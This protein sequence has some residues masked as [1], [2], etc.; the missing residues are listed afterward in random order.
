MKNSRL[1]VQFALECLL[2]FVLGSQLVVAADKPN[3][4]VIWGDDIGI[5]NISAYNRG[6]MGYA[7]PNIDRL[8]REGMMF[9]DYY[10]EQSCTA[11][12]SAFI[13]GQQPLR[14]GLTKVGSPGSSVGIQERDPTVAELIKP[15][16]YATG[17][18]GKNH[19][20]DRD[21]YLPTNHGFDEFTI[22]IAEVIVGSLRGFSGE[23]AT[24]RLRSCSRLCA[25][26][27][28]R[29]DW[30]PVLAYGDSIV[31]AWPA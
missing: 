11:D 24:S 13:T 8:A 7:T 21:E 19:L 28:V 2:G 30:G 14:T 18:F 20:G 4:L 31:R 16:G 1:N 6:I 10:G 25:R 15:L 23:R 26:G 17:Q 22:V 5:G 27:I 12:R 3:I 9:T 29:E